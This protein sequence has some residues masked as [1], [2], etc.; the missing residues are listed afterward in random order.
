MPR[1]KHLLFYFLWLCLSCFS[2]N[3]Y[4]DTTPN[5]FTF[6]DQTNVAL[7]TVI[8]SNTITISG[9]DAKTSISITGGSFSINNG[10]YRTSST[11]LSNGAT[12]KVRVTSAT[13]NSTKK[14]AVLTIG[15]VKD[16][17]SVTTLATGGSTDTTPNAFSF[18]DQT[19]LALNT[20]VTSNTIN[21]GGINA[22]SAI[23]VSGGSYSI[24]G[25]A[26]VTATGTVNN[27]NTVAI[28][29]TTAGTNGTTTNATLTV[30]G[31]SDIFSATTVA[32]TS[33]FL[34]PAQSTGSQSFTSE[35]FMGAQV[36][37]NCHNGLT[38][39]IT[40]K[41]VAIQKDWSATMMANSA[42]DP[43]WK[44]K[45]RSEINRAPHLT[46]VISDKC[47]RC[48]APMANFEAKSYSEP[49]S[50]LAADGGFL[51][52]SH[53]RHDEAM[54]GIGC[55]L[56]HQI[57]NAPN[58][59]TLSSF[60]GK[61]EI[62]NDK[63]IYGQYMD[64]FANPMIMQTGYTPTGSTHMESSKLCGTCH[65]LKTP[66]VD[67]S[68]NLLST[69]PE[70]EFPEQMPYSE[71]ENSDHAKTATLRTC[72]DCHMPHFESVKISTMPMM[73][74][75]RNNFGKHD[76]VGANKL[77][78]DIFNNN[79]TQLG[80][81]AATVDF[82]E[83]IDKTQTMLNSSATISSVS[84]SLA[85]DNNLNIT[86]KINSAT[87]H[88]LPSAYPSRRVVLHITVKDAANAIVFESGKVNAN[89][90]IVGVDA[91][92]NRATFEPHY[93]LITS[94][95][96]VQ[97][98]EAIMGNNL[99]EVTYT[100][101]RGMVYLKDNRILPTGFNKATAP[102][103]IKVVGDALT[104][105]NFVGGSDQ[106]TYRIPNLTGSNYTVEAELVHQPLAYSFAQ[107][108][109]SETSNEGDDFKTMFNASNSKTSRIA[110][111][112]FN[113]SR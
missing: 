7:N 15:G 103:D 47:T 93:D 30:G 85:A 41:D 67:H 64:P 87:G 99:N 31:I 73:L 76:F 27:G 108:L 18:T 14:D 49:K 40:G 89:G 17:F 92:I 72:Q 107:D 94:P 24:N 66:F 112:T 3:V 48:H 77:M 23:S 16:T 65:N 106:I 35:H 1:H 80:V 113:V 2:L 68:G 11:T 57:Q 5:Q 8:V 58:L 75:T 98:Y 102:N 71:W 29:V 10:S 61:Y 38:D 59:G 43:L 21:I 22:A 81:V 84:Q 82:N 105:T 97:V 39:T 88:K 45:V 78:L 20:A 6:T 79:K 53:P 36:C 34:L 44:A 110:L 104:D 62:G 90:S 54:S 46:D 51:N 26:F 4:A 100:L 74:G 33:G 91:D 83:T 37:S 13:T 32:A 70:S 56:C 69:T 111:N 52:A 60:T 9:I 42:R 86:L 63:K 55:T 101:L 109:F 28:K 12:V 19:N 50:I 25:G 95:D 96:Q